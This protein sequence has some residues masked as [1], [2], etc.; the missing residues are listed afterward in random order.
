V[1]EARKSKIKLMADLVASK[2]CILVHRQPSLGMRP[3]ELSGVPFIK[4]LI[5]FMRAPSS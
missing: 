1:L 3:K 2:D 4:A 5:P